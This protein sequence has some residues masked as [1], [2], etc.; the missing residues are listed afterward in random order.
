MRIATLNIKGIIKI[1]KRELIEKWMKRNN[2]DILAV[3]ETHAKTDHQE[4]VNIIIDILQ[5]TQEFAT[6]VT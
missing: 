5:V 1:G 3:Q 2:I 4:K 6:Q